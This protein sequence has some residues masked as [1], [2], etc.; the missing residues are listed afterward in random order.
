MHWHQR[1]A[2]RETAV[3][4]RALHAVFGGDIRAGA[5]LLLDDRAA[6]RRTLTR[7]EG[8]RV[9][10][11]VRLPRRRR[12]GQQNRYYFGVVLALLAEACG[13]DFDTKEER[14]AFHDAVAFKFL[15]IANHPVTGAPR[16]L[17]TPAMDTQEFW[18]YVERV[19]RW[20]AE[21]FALVIPDPGQVDA[22]YDWRGEEAA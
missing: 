18:A 21:T 16:R 5:Q 7:L 8:K 1:S 4:G 14:E 20:A 6:F 22:A 10:L 13:E 2:R 17:R 9:E 3:V 19:R 11:V 12:T 15:Q